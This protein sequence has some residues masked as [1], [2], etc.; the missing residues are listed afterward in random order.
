MS[1][2]SGKSAPS[3]SAEVR[4][5]G[6]GAP[7]RSCSSL[8]KSLRAWDSIWPKSRQC[9]TLCGCGCGRPGGAGGGWGAGVAVA[10]TAGAGVAVAGAAGAGVAVA[11]TA[12][13]GEAVATT[14]GAGVAVAGAA[15]AGVA[16]A[17]TAGAGVAV[18]TTAGAGVAVARAVGGACCCCWPGTAIGG[19]LA[20]GGGMRAGR[21]D[22]LARAPRGTA[23]SAVAATACCPPAVA[24]TACCPP[25]VGAAACC[26]LCKLAWREEDVCPGPGPAEATDDGNRV[27]PASGP[28]AGSPLA[29]NP[30]GPCC[31][32]TLEAGRVCSS[33][34]TAGCAALPSSGVRAWL[35]AAGVA[36]CEAASLPSCAT[37]AAG[38]GGSLSPLEPT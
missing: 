20:S 11:T 12:G 37:G 31:C 15:G 17:T 29:G 24:A 35:P 8:A 5:V 16:V 4:R 21:G 9:G 6:S 13:A 3:R 23:A 28:L 1:S 26:P 18:A 2:R 19:S 25:A 32:W 14:A 34:A 7:R 10:T 38:G 33:V 27:C 30:L 36:V 22:G